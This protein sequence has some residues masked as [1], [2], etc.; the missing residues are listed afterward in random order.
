MVTFLQWIVRLCALGL[1]ILGIGFW[2][3]HWFSLVPLHM[4]LGLI[5]VLCFW[6]T[7]LLA[8]PARAPVGM[9]VL[10]RRTISPVSQLFVE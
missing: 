3:G 9:V 10:R 5:L 6:I 1:V 4:T 2:T 8:V 7:A